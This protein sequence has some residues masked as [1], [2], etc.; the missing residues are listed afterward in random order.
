MFI[1]F[2]IYSSVLWCTKTYRAYSIMISKICLANK[3]I[4]VSNSFNCAKL[5]DYKHHNVNVKIFKQIL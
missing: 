4:L 5:V 1:Y 3:F 2:I